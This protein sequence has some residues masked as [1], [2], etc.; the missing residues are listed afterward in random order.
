MGLERN[1]K[2]GVVADDRTLATSMKGV[3]A[4]GDLTGGASSVVE[5][6]ASARKAAKSVNACLTNSTPADA[7][8]AMGSA[9]LREKIFP[10]RLE[11]LTPI[12]LREIGKDDA[13]VSFDEVLTDTPLSELETDARRCMKCGYIEIDHS[14]CVG[15]G[16]CRRVCPAGDV[17]TMGAP[18]S[19]GEEK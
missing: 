2:G 14:L 16:L 5:A 10:V 13:L 15:C 1:A 7:A 17:I 4:A 9:P 3:Y 6:M 8:P 12:K 19:G 18:L 11:K